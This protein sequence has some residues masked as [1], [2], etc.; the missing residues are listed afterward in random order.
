M[1]GRNI[2]NRRNI[3]DRKNIIS[4]K[5]FV[6][7]RS[8]VVWVVARLKQS[9]DLSGLEAGAKHPF[10]QAEAAQNHEKTIASRPTNKK[11]N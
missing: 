6:V 5:N 11:E 8:I 1:N 3:V 10:S 2:V 9:L 7:R 4:R